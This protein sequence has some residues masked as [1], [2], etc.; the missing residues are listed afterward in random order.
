MRKLK[1]NDGNEIIVKDKELYEILGITQPTLTKK[2]NDKTFGYNQLIMI[3]D[4]YKTDLNNV[5]EFLGY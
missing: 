2:R 5:Y 3:S 1:L 4:H